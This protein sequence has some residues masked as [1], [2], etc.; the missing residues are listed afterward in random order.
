LLLRLT[1]KLVDIE[2][3]LILDSFIEFH[4]LVQLGLKCVI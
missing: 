3:R 2:E 1:Q 4:V